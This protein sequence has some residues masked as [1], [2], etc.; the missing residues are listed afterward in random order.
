M[1]EITISKREYRQLLKDSLELDLLNGAGVD[2]WSGIDYAFD[3]S[4]NGG[5][6]FQ[7]EC[8][9]IDREYAD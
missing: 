3:S 9:R 8:D 5:F 4:E 6:D 7:E 2:N 1:S